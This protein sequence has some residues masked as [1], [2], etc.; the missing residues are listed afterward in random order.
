MELGGKKFK[1][2][3]LFWEKS[4]ISIREFE[5]IELQFQSI[6]K[7]KFMDHKCCRLF[8]EIEFDVISFRFEYLIPSLWDFT[9]NVLVTRR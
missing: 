7:K 6:S 8:Y 4:S 3:K 9:R 1:T 5:D 2:T